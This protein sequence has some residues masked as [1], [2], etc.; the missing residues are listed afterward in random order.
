MS[1]TEFGLVT[2]QNVIET[3]EKPIPIRGCKLSLDQVKAFY[4]DLQ[5]I[6]TSL[7]NGIIDG[8]P[9]EEDL[10]DEEWSRK[11]S[12]LKDDAFRL[13]VTIKGLHDLVVYGED[14]SIFSSSDLPNP[15]KSIYFNNVTAYRRNAAGTSPRNI[16]EVNLDFDKPALFDPSPN[17]SE[18]TPNNSRVHIDCAEMGFLRSIQQTTEAKLLN[19]RTW[20]SYLHKNFSYD[21]VLWIIFLPVVLFLTTYYTDR[22]IPSDS[23]VSSYRW[24]VYI[25]S[26]GVALLFFR[27]LVSYTKWAFPVNVLTNNNDKAVR[28]R[29]ILALIFGYI[30]WSLVDAVR[31]TIKA[32]LPIIGTG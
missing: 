12:F 24:A 20:Y 11:K 16:V 3:F 22:L 28:H 26:L 30:G 31:D 19:H 14:E 21:L 8:L 25:Y 32:T 13:T 2:R 15:I 10:T 5:R 9:K 23:S 4:A 27:F 1:D 29:V 18:A 6:N 7:G 17:I